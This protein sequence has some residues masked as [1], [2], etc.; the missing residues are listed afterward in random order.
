MINPK[1]R[2]F[3]SLI[4]VVTKN[5]PYCRDPLFSVSPAALGLCVDINGGIATCIIEKCKVRLTVFIYFQI[6]KSKKVVFSV[7][8]KVYGM[9]MILHTF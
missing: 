4:G 2:N 8:I 9:T 1:I 3:E 7:L 6:T 5:L